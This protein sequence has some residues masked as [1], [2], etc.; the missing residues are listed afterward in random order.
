MLDTLYPLLADYILEASLREGEEEVEDDPAAAEEAD[1]PPPPA[2]VQVQVRDELS[3][4]VVQT[5]ALERL[6]AGDLV[7]GR[8][9]LRALV[10]WAPHHQKK[11]QLLWGVGGGGGLCNCSL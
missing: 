8:Q 9:L 2:L 5:Y 7:T 1:G 4:R 10:R 3:R 6:A 11:V